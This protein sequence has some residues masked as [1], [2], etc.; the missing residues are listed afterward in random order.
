MLHSSSLHYLVTGGAGFIGSHLCAELVRSGHRVTVIDN[1]S[2][3]SRVNLPSGVRLIEADV[4]DMHALASCIPMV[5]G[6]FHLAAIASVQRSNEAW[7]DTSRTNLFGT[8]AVLD[9]IKQDARAQSRPPIPCV[10]ASS[11]AIYGDASVTPITESVVPLPL[12]AYG[13]DK[14]ASEH[15]ARIGALVHQIPASAMRFFNVYGERQ[16]PNSP[17]SGVISIFAQRFLR[18]A[19]VSIHG[20]GGQSRDFIYVGDVVRLLMAAMQQHHR[21]EVVAYRAMNVCTGNATTIRQLA[22]ILKELTQSRSVVT[23]EVPRMGDI[24]R[25]VGSGKYAADVLGLRAETSLTDGLR[26][27]LDWMINL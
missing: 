2:T 5:D 10:L 12:T 8:V 19:P 20:D 3:G 13:V 24:Y 7:L 21:E 26:A 11:A 25:S 9:A 16:D 1:L 17:Y 27:T 6:V 4:A 22:D 15:H 18:H 23:H 14:Y